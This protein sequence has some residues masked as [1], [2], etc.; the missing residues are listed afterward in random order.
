MRKNECARE[1][2]LLEALQ[3]SQWPQGTDVSL[4]DHVASCAACTQL[5]SVVGALLEDR[6]ELMQEA[7]VPSSAIVWWRAQMRSRREAAERAVQPIS[8]VQGIALACAV[9]LLATALGIF[10]PTFRRSLSWVAETLTSLSS[11]AVPVVADPL[12]SPIVLAGIAALGLC[13]V[14]LP[15]ALY[16]TFRED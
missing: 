13:V 11:L 6:Q 5:V 7:A 15:L 3:S 1:H 16:F 8:F 4:Q 10:V 12:A 9:G 2:E 14:V